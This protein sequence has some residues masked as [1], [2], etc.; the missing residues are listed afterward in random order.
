MDA[1][2]AVNSILQDATGKRASGREMLVRPKKTRL[3]PEAAEI[4]KEQWRGAG[5]DNAQVV[6]LLSEADGSN[7]HL[8]TGW[9]GKDT[10]V[11]LTEH[12]LCYVDHRKLEQLQVEERWDPKTR[13]IDIRAQQ[14]TESDGDGMSSID[15]KMLVDRIKRTLTKSGKARRKGRL[16]NIEKF[17]S[18]AVEDTNAEKVANSGPDSVT[19]L[20]AI[21]EKDD[22]IPDAPKE[23]KTTKLPK[24]AKS[25]QHH[26]ESF[27]WRKG[28]AP[29]HPMMNENATQPQL[30][31]R[32][33]VRQD[34]EGKGNSG[35]ATPGGNKTD[36][37]TKLRQLIRMNHESMRFLENTTDPQ[38]S[39]REH[40]R[41]DSEGKGGSGGAT[42]GGNKT[43]PQKEKRELVTMRH[44]DKAMGAKDSSDKSDK[45]IATTYAGEKPKNTEAS[46]RPK[47]TVRHESIG[48]EKAKK[49]F[50]ASKAPKKSLT[51]FILMGKGKPL[52]KRNMSETLTRSQ[53]NLAKPVAEST[54]S[55]I[56]KMQDKA[57]A[58]FAR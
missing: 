46:S 30:D 53:L 31:K 16:R 5:R 6:M 33:H 41:M 48:G 14:L 3:S 43:D 51:M 42:P 35:S 1:K 52:P 20:S 38:L 55:N 8:V 17:F 10:F 9:N 23:P 45:D 47:I 22:R 54:F 37:Q 7:P 32:E 44:E 25:D 57:R 40:V 18:V 15:V 49:L 26:R 34:S 56:Q 50:G 58:R 28:W 19:E 12:G 2:N 36:P 24:G 11:C 29:R 39:A 21:K 13:L 27:D 4:L